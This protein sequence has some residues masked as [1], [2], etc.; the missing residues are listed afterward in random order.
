M[1]KVLD[2]KVC[3]VN[4]PDH[5]LKTGYLVVRLVDSIL[6]Y[7]GLYDTADR[8]A[9]VAVELGTGLVLGYLAKKEET[10][11]RNSDSDI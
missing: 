6:W 4:C 8:A 11:E 10:D 2:V 1:G 3:V 5:P 7:Y 9:E